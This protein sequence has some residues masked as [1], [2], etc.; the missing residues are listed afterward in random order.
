MA[1]PNVSEIV[2][3]TI[4]HRNRVVADNIANTNAILSAMKRA[5]GF[6]TM[7]GGSVIFE[8]LNFAE[9]PNTG[10]YS[11]YDIL[12][13]Q[14][15][16]VVSTAQYTL[17]LASAQVV[18]SGQE[19]LQNSGKAKMIDLL[20]AKV[21]AAEST[22]QNL[23]VKG[24]YSDGTANS[25]KQL[26]GLKAAVPVINN[27]GVYG[28]IDRATWAFW[29]N[30]SVTVAGGL[31]RANIYENML[32]MY[33]ALT[34]GGKKANLIV[35][36]ENLFAM[37]N[38]SLTAD[39]RFADTDT[40]GRGFQNITFMGVP[41][42]MEPQSSGMPANTMY[43]LNTDYLKLRTHKDR[44]FVPLDLGHATNQDAITK[45]MGWAGNLTCSGA[46]YQGVLTSGV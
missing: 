9:N 20:D 19:M 1:T 6:K 5:G 10:W 34:K 28:G 26:T 12:P 17:K 33:L 22:I 40:A 27:T 30:K 38:M 24:I 29:R 2:A 21:G 45:A 32:N 15:S 39:Q 42:V 37:Y 7:D 13:L 25:G 8:E 4:E 46:Q 43:F 31:T 41:V 16:D 23:I 14:A 44:N 3:T 18:I 11:G 36:D 35:A